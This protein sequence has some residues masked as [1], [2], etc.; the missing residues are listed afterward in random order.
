MPSGNVPRVRARPPLQ[1]SAEFIPLQRGALFGVRCLPVG[2]ALKRNKFRAPRADPRFLN[3]IVPAK[4]AAQFQRQFQPPAAKWFAGFPDV[5]NEP[6]RRLAN[7]FGSSSVPA[8][9]FRQWIARQLDRVLAP[10]TLVPAKLAEHP[11]LSCLAPPFIRSRQT[12]Q[13][14]LPATALFHFHP[15][16]CRCHFPMRQRIVFTPFLNHPSGSLII[17]QLVISPASVLSVCSCSNCIYTA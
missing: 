1:G 16:V 15:S 12:F 17:T 7:R 14:F 6:S 2:I 3:R 5:F 9:C 13:L 10:A 8:F 11:P 4:A